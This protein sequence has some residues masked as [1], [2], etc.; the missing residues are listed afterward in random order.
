MWCRLHFLNNGLS[1]R[2][3]STAKLGP[4]LFELAKKYAC[5]QAV[6]SPDQPG[7]LKCRSTLFQFNVRQYDPYNISDQK[8]RHLLHYF[9]KD[10]ITCELR[11]GVCYFT[12]YKGQA[13]TGDYWFDRHVDAAKLSMILPIELDNV[14]YDLIQFVGHKSI[15]QSLNES[16]PVFFSGEH[17]TVRMIKDDA[18]PWQTLSLLLFLN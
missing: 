14:T 2:A 17:Q 7:V 15:R 8:M 1:V 10:N 9:L 5:D 12:S 16:R 4:P 18:M 11:S 13:N 6:R 3:Y